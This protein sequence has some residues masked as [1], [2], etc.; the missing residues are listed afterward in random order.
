[1]IQITEFTYKYGRYTAL[2]NVSLTIEKGE[3]AILAGANGAGKTTLLRA[4]SGVL[5]SPIG[6]IMIDGTKIGVETRRKTAYIPATLSAYDSYRLKDAAKMHA[7]FFPDF[8][9]SEIGGYRFDMNRKMGS[10]SRGEKTLFFL[11]LLLSTSP[12]YLLVDDVIHFLDPHL[13]DIFLQTILKLI[14]ERQLGMVIAAQVPL[15]IEGI[16][17]R[18][19]VFDRGKIALDESMENLK[20]TFVKVYSQQE[21]EGL[22]V[23]Y[24]KEWDGV[25]ELYIY[26]YSSEIK[27]K[28]D[29]KENIQYLD[30]AEILR[31]YIGG[32][33]AQ[34]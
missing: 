34:H 14:E 13:R 3:I 30:L 17:D 6:K 31:A 2:D 8:Q 24:R 22:P 7:T 11:S 9:Y 29:L 19:I 32:E 33:Y 1:M 4:I 15:D 21:P 10:L 27:E 20:R 23:V 12:Q 25:K 16:V 28:C 18:V 5:H 26:P